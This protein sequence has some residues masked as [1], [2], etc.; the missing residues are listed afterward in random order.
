MRAPRSVKTRT[1]TLFRPEKRCS[2]AHVSSCVGSSFVG[3]GGGGGG[4]SS[5]LCQGRKGAEGEEKKRFADQMR[6]SVE[7]FQVVSPLWETEDF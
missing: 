6:D 4:R 1:V 3:K 2:L 5:S 7:G